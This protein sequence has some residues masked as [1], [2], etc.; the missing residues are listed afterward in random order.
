MKIALVHDDLIQEGGAEKLLV[1]MH[2]IWPEAPVYTSFASRAWIKKCQELNIE[3][4]T[5]FMQRL[6]LKKR[7]YK[8]YFLL[9]PPAFESFNFDDFDVVLSSSARYA[10]GVITKPKTLHICYMNTPARM[11]WEPDQYFAARLWLRILLAPFLSFLRLWDYTAAQRVNFFIANS[12]TPQSRIKK[13]YGRESEIVYPFASLSCHSD[14]AGRI[15]QIQSKGRLAKHRAQDDIGKYF[16][17]VTRLVS[18]KRVEI[19][20]EA[21]KELGLSLVIVGRG[22]DL[23]RLKKIAE[24]YRQI[25]FHDQA[26]DE[27]LSKLYAGCQ[28]VIIT[29]AED[30]G[31]VAVEAASFKKLVIAF[32]A[33]GSLE[34]VKE[35]QTGQFFSPQTSE[36]LA[37][38]LQ[39]FG[40][41]RYDDLTPFAEVA[42]S[43]SK[44]KFK[45]SLAAAVDRFY[46]L[47]NS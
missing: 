23:K 28:A 12:K 43:F 17:V 15:P 29:Q 11:W 33:G 46:V 32:G 34:V 37:E 40:Q 5:S 10:H 14:A 47:P 35:G 25:K 22:Q 39:K 31:M 8:F 30:F 27:E 45:I 36:A 16:L 2:E 18:W 21:C 24:G 26:N 38:T 13:Y 20:I 6:P 1:A 7:L 41:V 44:E 19:A 4:R 42:E 9:F 3:L